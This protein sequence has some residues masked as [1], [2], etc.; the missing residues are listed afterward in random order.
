LS[1]VLILAFITSGHALTEKGKE[2]VNELTAA[3]QAEV[4]AVKPKEGQPFN[5]REQRV[6][7]YKDAK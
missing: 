4:Q 3:I 6:V 1:V 2:L 7:V 5:E